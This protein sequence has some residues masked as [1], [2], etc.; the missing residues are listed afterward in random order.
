MLKGKL[1]VGSKYRQDFFISTAKER[2][3]IL[4]VVF[5]IEAPL[6]SIWITLKAHG[7]GVIGQGA[8]S[9]GGRRLFTTFDNVIIV[10]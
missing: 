5:A 10:D 8:D 1:F 2:D 3:P 9:Y 4:N 6:N 7:Y